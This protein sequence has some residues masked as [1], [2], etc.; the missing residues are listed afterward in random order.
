MFNSV[1][2]KR[3]REEIERRRYDVWGV[4][5]GK[6]LRQAPLR[7]EDARMSSVLVR[8]RQSVIGGRGD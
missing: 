8:G 7:A 2:S 6:E 5:G 1:R 3:A 4:F